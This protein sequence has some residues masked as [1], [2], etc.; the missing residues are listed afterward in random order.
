MINTNQIQAN[1]EANSKLAMSLFEI[2]SKTLSAFTSMQVGLVDTAVKNTLANV[3][4]FSKV[5]DQKAMQDYLSS[6]KDQGEKEFNKTVENYISFFKG[7][8]NEVTS[9]LANKEVKA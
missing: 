6:V 1:L 5:K 3:N 9:A 2:N 7:Y 4:S 8:V